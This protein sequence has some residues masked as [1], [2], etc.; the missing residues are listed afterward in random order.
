MYVQYNLVE[1]TPEET[2]AAFA[3]RA[4][5]LLQPGD[6]LVLDLRHNRGG[7]NSRNRALLHAII[8]HPELQRPGSLYVL[9]GPA[10]FSAAMMLALDL[11]KHTPAIFV[12]EPT[13]GRPNHYG[14][15]RKLRLPHTGLTVR[16]STLY[17][18]YSDPRDARS[19]IEPHLVAAPSGAQ[20]L[21]GEDPAMAAV[22]TLCAPPDGEAS[23][24]WQGRA[25]WLGTFDVTVRLSRQQDGWSGSID[26]P[27][28]GL[29]AAP[30]RRM[31]V[32]GTAVTWEL[33]TPDGTFRFETRHAGAHLVGGLSQG[34]IEVPLVL[35]RSAARGR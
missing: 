19:A 17:W 24:T 21:R 9:I 31:N 32:A 20:W 16:V 5:G 18:Q 14:D 15:S 3:G 33:E 29:G 35:S 2:V 22:L 27:K 23:G 13:G 25:T 8:R 34:A 10:T 28:F 26:I 12:G 1:D 30:L 11:E 6:R 4:L 7:D